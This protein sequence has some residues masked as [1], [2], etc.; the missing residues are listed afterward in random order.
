MDFHL[1][2][3]IREFEFCRDRGGPILILALI[4]SQESSGEPGNHSVR[5]E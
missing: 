4:C 5:E 2:D 3:W 1:A